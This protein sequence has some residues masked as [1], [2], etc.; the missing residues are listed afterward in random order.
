MN[1]VNGVLARGVDLVL[2]KDFASYA[3]Q[4]KLLQ[5]RWWPSLRIFSFFLLRVDD[6]DEEEL[7]YA[8]TPEFNHK[9]LSHHGGG[10]HLDTILEMVIGEFIKSSVGDLV[11]THEFNPIHNEDLDFTPKNDRFDTESYLLESLLNH[12]TLMASSL[13]IDSLLGIISNIYSQ[14]VLSCTGADSENNVKFPPQNSHEYVSYWCCGGWEKT[15]GGSLKEFGFGLSMDEFSLLEA[16]MKQNPLLR[17][18]PHLLQVHR[19]QCSSSSKDLPMKLNMMDEDV[20]GCEG[21]LGSRT[22]LSTE[23]T[24]EQQCSLLYK[25]T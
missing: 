24:F 5:Q 9:R 22:K 19:L 15:F 3:L 8:I 6:D 4:K 7:Y 13:K 10:K 21:E 11:K 14:G 18:D 23:L 2:V 12:D 1:I 20:W 16:H 17:P 25:L